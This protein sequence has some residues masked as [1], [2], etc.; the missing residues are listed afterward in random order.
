MIYEYERWLNGIMNSTEFLPV[1][2]S[3]ASRFCLSVLERPCCTARTSS[4]VIHRMEWR[5][6]YQLTTLD[7]AII[8]Q[9]SVICFHAWNCRRARRLLASLLRLTLL[10]STFPGLFGV[11]YWYRISNFFQRFVISL[12]DLRARDNQCQYIDVFVLRWFGRGGYE[13]RTGVQGL[14]LNLKRKI[15][16]KDEKDV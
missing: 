9:Q 7:M 4:V 14:C 15:P 8:F 16:R 13:F 11:R 3:K 2:R 6:K 5:I 12:F 1:S 10:P